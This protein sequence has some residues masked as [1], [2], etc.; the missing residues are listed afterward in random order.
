MADLRRRIV[1]TI[2]SEA[3]TKD[4]VLDVGSFAEKVLLF[5]TLVLHSRNLQEIPH[6]VRRF[7]LGAVTRL[8]KS[9]AIELTVDKS[10][11]GFINDGEDVRDPYVVDAQSF[12]LVQ[13]ASMEKDFEYLQGEFESTRL[14]SWRQLRSA[15][16]GAIRAAPPNLNRLQ[17]APSELIADFREAAT[18]SGRMDPYLR[19]ALSREGIDHTGE[20]IRFE[21]SLVDN[22]LGVD[23]DI[24][25]LFGI[26]PFE[27]GCV[28]RDAL[29]GL[30]GEVGRVHQMRLYN[31][32]TPFSDPDTPLF[33]A[34][35]D[36]AVRSLHPT[37]PTGAF[38]RIVEVKDLPDLRRPEVTET[39]DLH[40]LLNARRSEEAASF[41]EWLWTAADLS[42]QDLT[43]QLEFHLASLAD[44]FGFFLKTPRGRKVRW[45][46]VQ[47]V[48]GTAAAG[49]AA[50]ASLIDPIA[51]AAAAAATAPAMSFAN[52]FLLDKVIP[53]GP[54][55]SLPA[56][57][58]HEGY[59]SIFKAPR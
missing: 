6:L 37:T 51:G 46:I 7:G 45:L 55:N 32:L 12:Q 8:F 4:I 16:K 24:E 19:A 21:V 41:R 43:E 42:D 23:T 58:V 10:S 40:A 39:I 2:F 53:T 3:D 1:S 13:P 34:H 44:K 47:G 49:A 17:E 25:H 59:P 36:Y 33:G 50:A 20:P 48:A 28:V 11:I 9:S 52:A 27:A 18:A 31:A 5:D 15:L 35:L 54:D 22:K 29:A 26:T 57:F 14:K 38:Y 56:T 30:S